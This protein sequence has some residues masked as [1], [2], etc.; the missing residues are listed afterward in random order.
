MK[1]I[2]IASGSE[3]HIAINVANVLHG[4]RVVS[5]PCMEAFDRQ[6]DS[7]KNSVL[8]PLCK[9][10]ISIEAGIAQ[11]WYKYIGSDGIAVSVENFGFSGQP[12]DLIDHFGITEK[13]LQNIVTKMLD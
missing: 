5:M 8:P 2:I 7:Y 10:R 13:N 3:L 4:V 11:P 9:K 1:A 6:P 12:K